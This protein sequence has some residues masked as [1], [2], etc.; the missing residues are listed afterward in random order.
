MVDSTLTVFEADSFLKS[1]THQPGIYQMYDGQGQILYIGK[2]KDLQKRLASY[3][4]QQGLA[5]KTRV[6]VKKIHHIEVTV[7]NT[8]TEALLLEHNLIK[9]QRPP[10][11]ISLRDDKSYPYVFISAHNFPRLTL[12]R[13]AKKAKGRYFGPYP[14]AGAVKESLNFLQKTFKVRQCEDSYFNNRSR[15]CLQYQIN[16]C[17]APCVNQVSSQDYADT[18]RR[19]ALFLEGKSK[20]LIGELADQMDAAA[21]QLDYEQ[22]AEY[23]DQIQNLQQLQSQQYIEGETGDIDIAACEL[24]AG[25]VCVQVLFVRDGRVL[26]SKSYFPRVYLDES[27]AQVL[28]AFL[29]QYYLAGASGR[30][31]P[32]EIISSHQLENN[33]AL[34]QVLAEQA[35]RKVT[36][37]HHVRSHRAKWLK[38]AAATAGHN[39]NSYLANRQTIHQRYEALQDL[40]SLPELPSRLECFDISHSS[41]EATVASCVVFDNNGPLKSDYRRFNID[42]ITPGDDYAAMHQALERRYTRIKSGEGVTPDILLIDG[43]KGQVRQATTV[44]D[45]LQINDVLVLGV[46]KGTTRKAGFETLYRSDTGAE[47]VLASDSPALHLIQYIRDESHR[48]AITG[49]KQRRDKKRRESPLQGIAGVGPKRRK[50]LLRHFGGWQEVI[51][52]S[53]EDLARVPGISEKLA[54]YIVAELHND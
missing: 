26:G 10:Y 45:V 15:P 24:R 5:A 38:L 1:V 53:A 9:Q 33:T 51:K 25:A 6:L 28:D 34:S 41:G 2:A 52:A 40:L 17:T 12:H 18:V 8:E 20:L 16:R 43:G 36:I 11:N 42:N 44:L 30:E 23:R 29:A 39:L 19:T 13:G 7:T 37:S 49:H 50:E 35:G 3:F 14:S 27:A 22:A 32:K 47:F 48:F 46:A 21:L 31:I 4:R 54:K